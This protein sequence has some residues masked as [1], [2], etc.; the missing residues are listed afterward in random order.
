MK[1]SS[2][3]CSQ[4][5]LASACLLA[6][7]ACK[8]DVV[9]DSGMDSGAVRTY[10]RIWR[11]FVPDKIVVTNRQADAV[12]FDLEGSENYSCNTSAGYAYFQR[13]ALAHGEKGDSLM[14]APP[15]IALTCQMEKFRMLEHSDGNA[16]QDVSSDYLLTF[17]F[18]MELHSFETRRVEKALT[19]L[20]AEDILWMVPRMI[21]ISRAD[22]LPFPDG[23]RLKLAIALENKLD[24][25]LSIN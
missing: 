20:T 8:E 21:V 15:G 11:Y 24:M 14:I 9:I 4:F 17:S 3:F 13:N 16:W 6:A 12:V 22:K 18:L 19:D 1:V 2:K 25:E 5:L 23:K 10:Y 7:V